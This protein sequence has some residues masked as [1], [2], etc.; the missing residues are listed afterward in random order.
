M[1]KDFLGNEISVG[2][3]LVCGAGGNTA[4]EYGMIL[5]KVVQTK[6]TLRATRLTASYP[7]HKNAVASHRTVNITNTNKYVVVDP[8]DAAKEL[9]E[10]IVEDASAAPQKD[11]AKVGKWVHGKDK[12][13]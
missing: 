5:L 4:C 3:W 7:D 1:V 6:P 11:H 10:R 12:V 8:P 13:F 9:F 2:T